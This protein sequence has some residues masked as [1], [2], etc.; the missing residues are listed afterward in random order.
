MSDSN[1]ELQTCFL[2]TNVYQVCPGNCRSVLSINSTW[3]GNFKKFCIAGNKLN[4]F[5]K[6]ENTFTVAV[7][8]FLQAQAK[9]IDEFANE[10]PDKLDLI[11][12]FFGICEPE[13]VKDLIEKL[14]NET[15]YKI[16]EIDYDNY[17]KVRKMLAKKPDVNNYFALKT[18]RYWKLV[19]NQ[20]ICNMIVYLVREK[21]QHK[22]A[23]QFL[24]ILPP[25]V[26]SEFDK[27]TDLSEDDERNLYL[28]L[29]D[30]IYNLP[31]IS[32]KIYAHMMN[33][34]KDDMEIFFI[35]DTMGELVKRR[36]QIDD[37]TG[38]FIKHFKK[39]GQ[40]LTIQWIYS[41]LYGLEYELVVEV[42]DQL[43]EKDY[44]S[45]SEKTTLQSLLKS[46]GLDY[47]KEMKMEIL[48]N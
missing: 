40:R 2:D 21:Q 41:E 4:S 33:L 9:V 13:D 16:L 11:R 43:R 28:A 3:M 29:E 39:S 20:R 32:P 46:G 10:G 12:Y 36:G 34:F 38:S 25:E 15:L 18:S 8:A 17:L 19:S 35:L 42:L 6:G 26:M 47:L 45:S 23:S 7:S 1:S 44:I 30:N 27:Y 48:N 31:L 14:G 22:L 24:L 5:I 37:I